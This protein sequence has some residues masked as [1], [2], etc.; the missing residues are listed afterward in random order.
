MGMFNTS[1]HDHPTLLQAL[2]GRPATLPAPDPRDPWSLR[3]YKLKHQVFK[4]KLNYNIG[5]W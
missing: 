5:F 4:L 1:P 2:K 3:T